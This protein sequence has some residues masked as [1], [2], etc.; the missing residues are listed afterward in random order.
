M[1]RYLRMLAYFLTLRQSLLLR[2]PIIRYGFLA[3]LLANLVNWGLVV[4]AFFFK[5]AEK[6][7]LILHSTVYF[8]I[9]LV[10]AKYRIFFY[11][12]LG[13]LM[14]AVNAFLVVLW[15][16]RDIFLTRGSAWFT[17]GLSLTLMAASIFLVTLNLQ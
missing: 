17:V 6:D 2:D 13:L 12:L 1:L 3:A 10:G 11:P 7:F 14:L 5:F 8:G 9:D 15:G 16:K 4:W